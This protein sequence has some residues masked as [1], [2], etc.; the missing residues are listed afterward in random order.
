MRWIL[1]PLCARVQCY[2]IQTKVRMQ[3]FYGGEHEMANKV[4]KRSKRLKRRQR[5]RRQQQPFI[6]LDGRIR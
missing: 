5:Q 2:K 6:K 4:K 3:T 1:F